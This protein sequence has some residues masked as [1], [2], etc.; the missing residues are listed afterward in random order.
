MSKRS[1]HRLNQ[2]VREGVEGKRQVQLHVM[3]TQT[4]RIAELVAAQLQGLITEE[5][6]NELDRR[7]YRNREDSGPPAGVSQEAGAKADPETPGVMGKTCPACCRS[8]VIEDP[9]FEDSIVCPNCHSNWPKETKC[10]ECG[11]QM[12]R[13]KGFQFDHEYMCSRC[14]LTR[15][16]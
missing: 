15:E 8:K 12:F 16:F 7:G 13:R 9:W 5:V 14:N 2:R 3:Q 10:P 6:A 11:Y 1:T 4:Q